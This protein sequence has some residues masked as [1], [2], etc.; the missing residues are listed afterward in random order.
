MNCPKCDR[1]V[2]QQAKYCSYCGGRL[3]VAC[4]SCEVLNPSDGRFCYECGQSLDG[5][6][7]DPLPVYDKPLQERP[8]GGCPR[9][10][11]INEPGA[12][13]CYQCGL[14]LEEESGSISN[15]AG[16]ATLPHRYTHLYSSP[17]ILA[18]WT[19]G[20][21]VATCITYV[22]YMSATFDLLGL[23]SNQ[24][25]ANLKTVWS[26]ET[27]ALEYILPQELSDALEVVDRMSYVSVGAFIATVV[28]FLMWMHRVSRNLQPLGAHGQRFS[29]GWAV[30]WWFIP[31][32]F[33]FRP[34]QV[35][36]EIWKGSGGTLSDTWREESVPALL[37]WWW[38]LWVAT[39]AIVACAVVTEF[40][41]NPVA[42]STYDVPSASILRWELLNGALT[43][44]DGVLAIIV[45]R[46][47][48][49]RQEEAYRRMTTG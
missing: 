25:I 43:I 13:Y 9:C 40:V 10:D 41:A 21:L 4:L 47:I 34:F 35:M 31:I 32:F 6:Q 17:R 24:D 19:I 28:L 49:K 2:V 3:A 18:G 1:E 8:A 39:Y 44:C 38:A 37:P 20:L 46:L 22:L 7:P 16:S 23:V 15:A 48:T 5:S 11:A 36:A 45:V 42:L 30:G 27:L 26:T 14:P 33:L 12:V 29:P